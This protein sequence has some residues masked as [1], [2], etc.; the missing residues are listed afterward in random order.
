MSL[1]Y[2][3]PFGNPPGSMQYYCPSHATGVKLP[4]DFAVTPL[5]YIR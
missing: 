5:E 3:D 1:H 4:D 2:S